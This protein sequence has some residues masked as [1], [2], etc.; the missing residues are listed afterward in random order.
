VD[1]TK[2]VK[3]LLLIAF[4]VTTSAH[5]Q[6]PDSIYARVDDLWHPFT[7]AK[8]D[9][10]LKVDA[11]YDDGTVIYRA[12]NAGRP[13]HTIFRRRGICY[14]APP[15]ELYAQAGSCEAFDVYHEGGRKLW[16]KVLDT[17]KR[18]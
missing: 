12:W 1:R 11:F 10:D 6:A 4:L 3:Y 16:K 7:I 18:I 17:V 13:M 14:T 5:A 8:L 2:A 9:I 15:G